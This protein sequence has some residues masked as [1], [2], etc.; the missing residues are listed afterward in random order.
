MS[1]VKVEEINKIELDSNT[2]WQPQIDRKVFKK[3]TQRSNTK[4]WFHTILY[5]GILFIAGLIACITWG[6]WFAIPAF[7]VYGTIYACSNARWHEYGHRTVFKNRNLNELFYYISSFLAFFEPISWRWSHANHHSKTRHQDLD[8][9]IADP[10]P[11][12][13]GVLLFAEFF[14]IIV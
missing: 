2:W 7:F 1:K 3:L 13:L 14:V 4:A 12:N 6:T 8:L 11:T 9:E 5:F 10:R